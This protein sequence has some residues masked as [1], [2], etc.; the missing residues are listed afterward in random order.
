MSPREER[1]SQYDL[2]CKND[3]DTIK[4]LSP[5]YLS[6]NKVH[7]DTNM[8]IYFK[9]ADGLFYD[10]QSR[11]GFYTT[12]YYTFEKVY[13]MSILT[14]ERLQLQSR[15]K[16]SV[17]KVNMPINRCKYVNIPDLEN[18]VILNLKWEKQNQDK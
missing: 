15:V 11:D 2:T 18:Q 9:S 4:H 8:H 10:P 13:F 1:R 17:I 7:I 6:Q 16:F 5:F 3:S 14:L 12:L